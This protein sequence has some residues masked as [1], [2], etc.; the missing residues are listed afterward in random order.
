[1]MKKKKNKKVFKPI[2]VKKQ[3]PVWKLVLVQMI[4]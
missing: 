2:Q 3:K 4:N 1:M